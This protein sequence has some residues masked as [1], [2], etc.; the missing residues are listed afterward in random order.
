MNSK[1]LAAVA[2]VVIV[3]GPAAADFFWQGGG[4]DD[5][6]PD[7]VKLE[8]KDGYVAGDYYVIE[9]VWTSPTGET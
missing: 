4:G 2:V 6:V 8:L 7:T 3:V 1:V 5:E 9:D